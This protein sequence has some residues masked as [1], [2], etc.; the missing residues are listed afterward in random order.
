MLKSMA[1][2][3]SRMEAA[4]K[5]EFEKQESME[6]MDRDNPRFR[7]SAPKNMPSHGKPRFADFEKYPDMRDKPPLWWDWF[8]IEAYDFSNYARVVEMTGC[9][10]DAAREKC[11]YPGAPSVRRIVAT[12]SRDAMVAAFALLSG[13]SMKSTKERGK[14]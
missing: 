9:G 5:L 13:A 8:V 12:G 4:S 6:M 2:W 10:G 11:W 3:F 14:P 7:A 1:A